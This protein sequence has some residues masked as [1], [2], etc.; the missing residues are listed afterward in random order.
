[1]NKIEK[2]HLE[3]IKYNFPASNSLE[4]HG[5]RI[6]ATSCAEITKEYAGKF[7]EWVEDEGYTIDAYD[8]HDVKTTFD[9]LWERFLNDLNEKP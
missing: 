6:A 9:V 1:M 7:A 5:N 8:K 2:E 3:V 4:R